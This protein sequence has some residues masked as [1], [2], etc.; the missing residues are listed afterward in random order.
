[1]T[2]LV[3]FDTETTGLDAAVEEICQFACVVHREGEPLSETLEMESLCNPGKQ[4]DPAAAAIHKISDEMVKDAVPAAELIP[5]W[6]R[7]IVEF[8]GGD[9]IVL[10]GHNTGFDWKF[11]RRH[12]R[13]SDRVLP[14]CTMRMA[15]RID[16]LADNHKLE[17]LYRDRFNLKSDRTVRAHDALSDVWMSFELL[18]HWRKYFPR[19]DYLG[20]AKEL[21]QP[22]KLEVMP[23]GKHKG[24]PFSDIPR[25]YLSW[26]AKQ[27]ENMDMDVR[28]TAGVWGG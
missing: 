8:A 6:F 14:L 12:L 20:I 15:R 21:L 4:I 3:I 2:V 26:L 1:M 19:P 25:H 7:E 27:D 18:Q 9:D 10:G 16:P 23:F 13:I 5:S 28:Y 11:L 17:Y 24:V 22:I